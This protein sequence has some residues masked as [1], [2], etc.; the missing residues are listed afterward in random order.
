MARKIKINA[1][2]NVEIGGLILCK[3][4]EERL[5][6]QTRYYDQLTKAQMESVDN[7]Y[8]KENHPAMAKFSESKAT[9]TKG[10]G[11]GTR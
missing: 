4:P 6:A 9:T 11:S 10:F 8:M 3:M 2:G 1:N 7:T 5:E